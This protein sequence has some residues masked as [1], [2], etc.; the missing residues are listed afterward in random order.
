MKRMKLSNIKIFTK[1]AKSIPS[2][3]KIQECKLYWKTYGCQDRDI[4]LNQKGYLIDGYIQYLVLQEQNEKYANVKIHN[5]KQNTCYRNTPTTYVYGRHYNINQDT[6]SKEYMWR[7]PKAWSKQSWEDGLNIGD[8][9]FVDTKYGIKQIV[10]T[11]IIKKDIC[12]VDMRVR[13]V[14]SKIIK[15]NVE[16]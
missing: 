15:S 6:Y 3:E 8:E 11:N 16:C 2:E 5:A 12:P 14:V 1:F 9:I 7:V 13:K 10:V 4:I